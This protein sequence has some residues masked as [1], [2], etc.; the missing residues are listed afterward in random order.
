MHTPSRLMKLVLPGP[1]GLNTWQAP[2]GA[3]GAKFAPLKTPKLKR[4]PRTTAIISMA[5][6]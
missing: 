1:F 2:G 4:A 3:F 6:P 5:Q